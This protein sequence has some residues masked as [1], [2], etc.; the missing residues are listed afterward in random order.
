MGQVGFRGVLR[1]LRCPWSGF[2]GAE[3]VLGLVLGV[4]GMGGF[5]LRVS[6]VF[7]GDLGVVL[8]SLGGLGS[9]WNGAGLV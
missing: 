8:G 3:R 6:W 1:L 9:P 2:T 7:W 5:G 4:P